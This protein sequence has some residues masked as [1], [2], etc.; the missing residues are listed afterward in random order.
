METLKERT[1]QQA[2]EKSEEINALN[3]ALFL[4]G[5]KY[6]SASDMV[7][8]CPQNIYIE[9]WKKEEKSL[10]KKYELLNKLHARLSK[11]LDTICDTLKDYES[12]PN[13]AKYY[14]TFGGHKVSDYALQY[15]RLDYA[16]MS[17]CFDA[18]LCNNIQEIDP[19]IF[20]NIESGDFESY[21]FKG[22]EI[23]QEEYE[24]KREEIEEEIDDLSLIDLTELREEDRNKI[25]D[26]IKA[27]ESD[28]ED[29]ETYQNEVFQWFI[30]SDNAIDLLKEAN[31]LVFYSETL[32]CYIWGVTHWGTSWDYVLTSIKLQ[33][34]ED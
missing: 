4:V 32:D 12:N 2:N 3:Y 24:E 15:G 20:D 28:L 13:K 31:E 6:K 21:Y 16:T 10:S 11:E 27:L 25:S 17:K 26:R 9:E 8:E 19:Y 30:V 14:D 29:F 34:R 1:Q 7:K 5:N 23:T 18:V 33:E 22:E